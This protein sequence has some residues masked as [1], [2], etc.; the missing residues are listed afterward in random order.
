MAAAQDRAEAGTPGFEDVTV[1]VQTIYTPRR[2]CLEMEG[3][4]DAGG[5]L[6]FWDSLLSGT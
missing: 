6:G 2:A 3:G 5:E 1:K 4:V